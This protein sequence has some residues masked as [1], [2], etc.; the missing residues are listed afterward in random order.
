[1]EYT[2]MNKKIKKYLMEGI[3]GCIL[4]TLFLSPYVLLIT[5]LTTLQY[6]SWV[7][8]EIILIIPLAPIV[9]RLTKYLMKQLRDDYDKINDKL[10]EIKNNNTEIKK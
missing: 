1:M 6:I 9:F 8:M 4:W 5:K 10:D 3:I 7:I 2:K